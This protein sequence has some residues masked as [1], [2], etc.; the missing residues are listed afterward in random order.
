MGY[1]ADLSLVEILELLT[2]RADF[3]IYRRTKPWDHAAGTLML[4]ELGGDAIAFGGQPYVPA[5]PLNAGVI[6]SA[7][8]EVLAEARALFD[9]LQLP[10]LTGLPNG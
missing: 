3:S 8:S 9:A 7:R 5:Q 2:G 1:A 6:G 10:L 4:R